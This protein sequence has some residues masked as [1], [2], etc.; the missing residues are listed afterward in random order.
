MQAHNYDPSTRRYLGATEADPDQQRPGEWLY[1]AFSTPHEPPSVAAGRVAVFTPAPT[2]RDPHAGVWH[3]EDLPPAPPEPAPVEADLA[4]EARME[5][6][7]RLRHADHVINR[8][9]DDG[10]DASAWRR[11]RSALRKVPELPGFPDAFEWPEV[12]A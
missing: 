9:E 2:E 7:A 1:P 11:Y 4:A 3:V 6:D 8:L 12:P 10:E 5:R